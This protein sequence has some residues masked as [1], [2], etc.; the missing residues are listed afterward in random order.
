VFKKKQNK[1]KQIHC[2]YAVFMVTHRLWRTMW[3]PRC[4]SLTT[5]A[6]KISHT[7]AKH[8]TQNAPKWL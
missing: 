8:V 1:K 5:V 3:G 7:R 2:I 4:S 6:V